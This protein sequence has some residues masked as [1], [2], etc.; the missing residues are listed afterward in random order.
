MQGS[1]TAEYSMDPHTERI[2][3]VRVND[4]GSLLFS[5]GANDQVDLISLES[6]KVLH[7]FK[8]FGR[9]DYDRAMEVCFRKSL[10]FAMNNA[11]LYMKKFNFRNEKIWL[12]KSPSERLMS[13]IYAPKKSYFV[14]GSYDAV[15]VISLK[16]N[17]RIFKK[18]CAKIPVRSLLYNERQHRLFVISG[19][20]L[21]VFLTL[22][23]IYHE[24][25]L[26]LELAHYTMRFLE[27][28]Q[29]LVA[30]GGNKNANIVTFC[31]DN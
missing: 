24:T 22:G 31:D 14:G 6:K 19:S 11:C 25:S 4:E 29:C 8:D 27:Q 26:N 21:L 7:T 30:C 17:K 23:K 12:Y 1:F 3:R 16:S 13:V 9:N 2:Y 20:F 10:I 18:K 5:L 15:K 28:K